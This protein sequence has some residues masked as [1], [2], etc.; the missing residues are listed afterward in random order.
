MLEQIFNYSL[1]LF[2]LVLN[3]L[4]DKD[5]RNTMSSCKDLYKRRDIKVLDKCYH[6]KILNTKYKVS[7]LYVVSLDIKLPQSVTHITFGTY[8]DLPVDNLPQSVTH[9]VFRYYF[10]Q[11][12]DNLP[13]SVTHIV[14]SL[15]HI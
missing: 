10:D 6:Q 1:D 12:V 14:L 9:I 11:P 5:Y 15:I 3:Y 2:K 7:K 8:F 13:Q 4:D